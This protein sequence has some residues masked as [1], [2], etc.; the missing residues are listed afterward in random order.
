[1][2]EITFRTNDTKNNVFFKVLSILQNSVKDVYIFEDRRRFENESGYEFK[3]T[4]DFKKIFSDLMTE[5]YLK[6]MGF[7]FEANS[8]LICDKC[9]EIN[10][11]LE[12][13][14]TYSGDAII[15]EKGSK[16]LSDYTS[17]SRNT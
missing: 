6:D 7:K 9:S 8:E 13:D 1:M 11:Y 14:I 10:F 15:T 12:V 2:R 3:K 4:D 17:H 16:F 5:G